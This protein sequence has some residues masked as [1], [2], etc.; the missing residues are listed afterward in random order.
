MGS[1]KLADGAAWGS[2][3]L[4][5]LNLDGIFLNGVNMV[6]LHDD[7]SHH[8]NPFVADSFS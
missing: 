1:T 4:Q 8:G 3:S 2:V 7:D 6:R 5:N